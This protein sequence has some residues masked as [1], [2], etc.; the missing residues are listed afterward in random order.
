ML[1]EE[2]GGK[3]PEEATSPSLK[4]LIGISEQA[5]KAGIIIIL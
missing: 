1:D 5:R 2:F 3:K 4:N